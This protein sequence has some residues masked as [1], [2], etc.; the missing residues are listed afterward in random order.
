[1]AIIEKFLLWLEERLELNNVI[2]KGVQLSDTDQ[3]R[4]LRFR[5]MYLLVIGQEFT[6]SDLSGNIKIGIILPSGDQYLFAF[7]VYEINIWRILLLPEMDQY[8]K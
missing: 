4:G 6:G 1:M 7:K 3:V 2:R 8:R 5:A